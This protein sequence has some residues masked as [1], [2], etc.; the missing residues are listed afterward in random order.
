MSSETDSAATCAQT[1]DDGSK[2]P[3]VWRYANARRIRVIIDGEAYFDAIQ[4]A[5]LKAQ[6]RILMIGWDFDTRIHLQRGRR[7][8]ERPWNREYP[9]RLGSFIPWLARRNKKLEIRILKWSF[10]FVKF[11]RRGSMLLDLA[12]WLPHRRI[13]FKFDTAHPVGCSHHQKIVVIDKDLAICGGIDLTSGRWDTREHEENDDRRR[14]PGREDFPPWHDITM[15][16]EGDAAGA[17]DELGRARWERAGGKALTPPDAD[18][19]SAWPDDL[20]AHFENV[21]LGIARTRPA[22]NGEEAISEIEQLH[23]QHIAEA[24]RYI[25]AENQ[26]FASRKIAEAIARRL[27]EDD[28]PEIV[29]VHPANA[30]GWLEAQ[31][32]DPARDALVAALEQLDKHGRFHIYSPY[33]HDTPIYVHAKLTIIDNRILRIGSANFNNRSM[34]LDS[35]CDLFIDAKRKGND[36]ARGAIVRLHHSLLAEHLGLE[37]GDLPR[38]LGEH[39]SMSALIATVGQSNARHLRKVEI[40]DQSTVFDDPKAR[41]VLDPERPDKMFEECLPENGLFRKG[42]LLA[43]A[44]RKAQRGEEQ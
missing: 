3:G 31:A 41:Q 10:G 32:M 7:W 26:Y 33:R 27:T 14:G 34:G 16:V 25:Y 22:Y 13:D 11:F 44:R 24:K 39:G 40:E 37:E 29:I 23:L 12:R 30:D 15:M 38:L 6:Q 17:L 8:W 9:S 1:D 35:E 19:P 36:H 42:S 2:A 20:D 18:G 21:E 28:P 4:R 43:K 5:M